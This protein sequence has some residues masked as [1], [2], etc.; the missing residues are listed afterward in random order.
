MWWWVGVALAGDEELA[1]SVDLAEEADLQFRLGIASYRAGNFMP[2]LEHL[3]ASHRLV[4]NRNVVFNLARTYEELGELDSAWRYYDQYVQ[5]E[6]D[7]KKRAEA[8]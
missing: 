2:A 6:P 5:A 7:P 3:L 8:E 4:P 1:P